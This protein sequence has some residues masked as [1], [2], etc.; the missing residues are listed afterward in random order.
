MP[1]ESPNNSQVTAEHSQ[2]SQEPATSQDSASTQATQQTQTPTVPP[3]ESATDRYT[4]ILEATLR[5]QNQR[6][7]RYEQ[8]LATVRQTPVTAPQTEAPKSDPA[9]FF[10]DPQ[11]ELN[12]FRQQINEDLQRTVAPLMDIAKSFRGEGTPYGNVKQQFLNDPRYAS[13]LADPKVAFAV[14]KIMENQQPTP[15]LMK[16]AIIQA[17]GLKAT[18]ELDMALVASGVDITR[19]QP[20]PIP[21]PT[22]TTVPT[23]P[24]HMRPSAPS[25]PVH[26]NNTPTPP[27]LTALEKRLAAERN[28]TDDAYRAWIST[29]PSE[30]ATSQIGKVQK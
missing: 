7:Q 12:K 4:R 26:Q 28:M 19:F 21:Q 9:A 5:E 29:P 15:E 25:S 1:D 14:D 3:T 11:G 24:A 8:D 22:A 16:A 23:I 2:L 10:N 6:I 13:Q 17:S 27:P 18:G 20:T 30:V